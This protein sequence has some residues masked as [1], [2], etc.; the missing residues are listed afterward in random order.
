MCFF[1]LSVVLG[2]EDGHIPT[3][4][5]LL[6]PRTVTQYAGNWASPPVFHPESQI[7]GLIEQ[8]TLNHIMDPYIIQAIFLIMM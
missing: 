5:L 2:S 1:L 4:G 6:Y 8:Y 7:H 3:F